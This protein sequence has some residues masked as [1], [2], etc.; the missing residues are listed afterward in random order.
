MKI[1]DIQ[2]IG[3]DVLKLL[4]DYHN[5]PNK[6]LLLDAILLA[7][8]SGR[9]SGVSR[10]HYVYLY[11]S[12]KPQRI[13]FRFGGNNP[14]V[15]EFAVRNPSS[16]GTLYGSQ[17]RDELRKLCRVSHTQARLRVLLLLDLASTSHLKADLKATYETIHA[18]PGKFKRSS[19]RV[20]YVHR[21][22]TFNF[23]WRP[24]KK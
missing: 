16:V 13:D 10:Q 1:A 4:D 7:Y 20:I 11:G 12:T 8:L 19:V 18:G 9:F 15:M 5:P 23:V 2:L 22:I 17:N 14:V 3:S 6:E 24:F 21:R